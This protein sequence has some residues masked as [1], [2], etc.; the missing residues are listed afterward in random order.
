MKI[1]IVRHGD[2]DYEHD[3][4]TEK[5]VREAKL[6]SKRLL[7]E[8]PYKIYVSPLG[9]AQKTASY[10][11]EESGEK[12]ITVD[13]LKEFFHPVK[14]KDGTDG[15][16]WDLY[17]AFVN[18]NTDLLDKD[19]WYDNEYM[20]SGNIKE[21]YNEV[22]NGFDDLLAENGYK[23]NGL[24]Y[25]ATNSNNNTIILFCHFGVECVLLSHLFNTSPVCLWQGFCAAPTSVTTIYTEE[26]EKGIAHFR[27][28]SF[29][30]ISHLYAAD[31]PPAFSA[32]FC[33]TYD[34]FE[35]RH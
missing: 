17:P 21:Y 30:D 8:K 9:R 32:R 27:C 29:G 1:L 2:P 16:P 24:I 13:W 5:G 28:A 3:S 34:N 33:E 26:R 4:L 20:K 35:Q 15:I 6:L 31:E 18:E 22:I 19:K 25:N 14:H 7:K 23:R 10:Y 12:F 11:L